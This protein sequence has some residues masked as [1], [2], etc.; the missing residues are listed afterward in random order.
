[1]TGDRRDRITLRS[2]RFGETH[3]AAGTFLSRVKVRRFRWG[4]VN[5]YVLCRGM[6]T[7]IDRS[8]ALSAPGLALRKFDAMLLCRTPVSRLG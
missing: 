6:Y 2:S 7:S 3:G 1:M 5:F 4:N 8:K